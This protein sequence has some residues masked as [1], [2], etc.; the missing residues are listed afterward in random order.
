MSRGD[1]YIRHGALV[2]LVEFTNDADGVQVWNVDATNE[3]GD[4]YKFQPDEAAH[5]VATLEAKINRALNM[6]PFAGL[7]SIPEIL[8]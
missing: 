8:Y 1:F 4:A 2:V 5:F 6:A 7:S 3:N